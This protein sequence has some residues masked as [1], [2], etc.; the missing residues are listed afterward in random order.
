MSRWN[1][2]EVGHGP[3]IDGAMMEAARMVTILVAE[4]ET[5]AATAVAAMLEQ[6]GCRVMGPVATVAEAV[7]CLQQGTP[8]AAVLD[9]HLAGAS[10]APVAKALA[11]RGVPF[12]L[13]T[14]HPCP[15]VLDAVFEGAPRLGRPFLPT[16]LAARVEEALRDRPPLQRPP[17]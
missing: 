14:D 3:T 1:M 8:D 17:G 4:G 13:A 10:T 7:A 12:V 2:P 16:V 11:E 5:P 15:G 9:I 6:A